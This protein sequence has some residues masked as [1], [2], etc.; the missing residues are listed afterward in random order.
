MKPSQEELQH[1]AKETLGW[2]TRAIGT[3]G[4]PDAVFWLVPGYA[5]GPW[6]HFQFK[7]L[8]AYEQSREKNKSL[9]EKFEELKNDIQEFADELGIENPMD[10]PPVNPFIQPTKANPFP[11]L[12][13]IDLFE[14]ERV[15][16]LIADDMVNA[17]TKAKS[18]PFGNF[19]KYVTP[20]EAHLSLGIPILTMDVFPKD[21]SIYTI[22]FL[23]RHVN[24]HVGKQRIIFKDGKPH[25]VKGFD[26][27]GNEFE[28]KAGNIFSSWK[29]SAKFLGQRLKFL[30]DR[31]ALPLDSF[32]ITCDN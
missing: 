11:S 25:T 8:E 23:A 19:P 3:S 18:H 5:S 15:D 22:S 27:N 29:T 12:R 2:K 1:F 16:K 30:S 26:V 4:H 9:H 31:Y 24:F 21:L 13:E 20:Y 32:V 14:K 17:L 10:S 6:E 28:V 7:A